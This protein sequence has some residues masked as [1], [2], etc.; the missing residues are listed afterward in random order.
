MK[1]VEMGPE[2]LAPRHQPLTCRSGLWPMPPRANW[3]SC[4]E[5]ERKLGRLSGGSTQEPL[6]GWWGGGGGCPSAWAV[7]SSTES[8]MWLMISWFSSSSCSSC[9]MR[10]CSTEIW[11][12]GHRRCGQDLR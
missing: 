7:S 8:L 3:Q 2:L 11:L 9:S 10:F 12:W 6:G 5:T 4:G 1:Q